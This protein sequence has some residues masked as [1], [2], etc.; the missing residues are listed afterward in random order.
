[1]DWV[2][3]NASSLTHSSKLNI[4]KL[5]ACSRQ[6][7]RVSSVAVLA[8]FQQVGLLKIACQCLQTAPVGLVRIVTLD[9]DVVT[10]DS[11]LSIE[12][13]VCR[14]TMM[15]ESQSLLYSHNDP[16]LD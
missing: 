2:A 9:A 8:N 15:I 6:D 12:A 10:Q 13:R 1:M 11:N 14:I 16:A 3:C 7:C 4:R 5:K